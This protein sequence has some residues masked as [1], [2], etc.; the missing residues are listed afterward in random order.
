MNS[1]QRK[2]QYFTSLKVSDVTKKNYA[3]ALRS[4][5]LQSVLDTEC[6]TTDL[7]SLEDLEELED[8]EDLEGL[9]E[10][11]ELLEDIED[12]LGEEDLIK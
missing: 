2:Y 6:G 4:K 9:G 7:F 12:L 3:S 5:F 10:I 1:S 11:E 8:L